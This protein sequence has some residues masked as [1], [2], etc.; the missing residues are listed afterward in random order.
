MK[1]TYILILFVVSFTFSCVNNTHVQ[2]KTSN[3]GNQT[4]GKPTGNF[5]GIPEETRD[6]YSWLKINATPIPPAAN[7]PHTPSN[8]NK[9]IFV[10]QAREILVKSGQQV[11]PYPDKS[12]IVKEALNKEKNYV[13]LIAI[14]KKIAG[15]DPQH[16]DWEFTEYTRNSPNDAFRLSAKDGICWSCH[17]GAKETDYVFEKLK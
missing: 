6:Y 12:I 7:A 9:N 4:P 13:E 5:A 10:N 3:P 1:P 14:M 8:G 17:V 2:D 15:K 11:F 16:N